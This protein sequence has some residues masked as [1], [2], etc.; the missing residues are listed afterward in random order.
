VSTHVA[1]CFGIAKIMKYLRLVAKDISALQNVQ[2]GC[3]AHPAPVLIDFSGIKR[4][5]RETDHS[6]PSGGEVKNQ[7]AMYVYSS[8]P[9]LRAQGNAYSCSF[10]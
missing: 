9:S 5:G 1:D 8:D 2:T 3:E 7:W 6:P 10:N 4:C